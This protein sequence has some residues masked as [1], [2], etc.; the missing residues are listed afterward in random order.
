MVLSETARD[1]HLVEK[2]AVQHEY[3]QG[4]RAHYKGPSRAISKARFFSET[5]HSRSETGF[6]FELTTVHRSDLLYLASEIYA[7]IN[8]DLASV[9]YPC[10]LPCTYHL[11]INGS[12]MRSLKRQ[13]AEIK[14]LYVVEKID[15]LFINLGCYSAHGL[16]HLHV[17][18]C[19]SS[20]LSE[21]RFN[22][23][24]SKGT[25]AY[26][27]KMRN[28][29][30]R[31]AKIDITNSHRSRISS[32]K[33]QFSARDYWYMNDNPSRENILNYAMSSHHAY[34]HDIDGS[35]IKAE[36][37]FNFSPLAVQALQLRFFSIDRI[38]N[39]K[40]LK[41]GF[42]HTRRL[43][44]LFR[45]FAQIQCLLLGVNYS[46]I[47]TPAFQKTLQSKAFR[48]RMNDDLDVIERK[49]RRRHP[50][51][52][53]IDFPRVKDTLPVRP[54]L[55]ITLASFF[56]AQLIHELRV[57]LDESNRQILP[58]PEIPPFSARKLLCLRSRARS[59]RE[60]Y[61]HENHDYTVF[62]E[63]EYE[64]LFDRL[65]SVALQMAIGSESLQPLRILIFERYVYDLI[66]L[67][68]IKH[69]GPRPPPARKEIL[70]TDIKE[71]LDSLEAF[72]GL[73]PQTYYKSG[74]IEEGLPS[75][76]LRG[77][78]VYMLRSTVRTALKIKSPAKYN[79]YIVMDEYLSALSREI[80]FGLDPSQYSEYS[81]E[82]AEM[83]SRR[84]RIYPSHRLALKKA[85]GIVDVYDPAERDSL[86][87]PVSL[88]SLETYSVEQ[89]A[90]A[91][92][93]LNTVYPG[94]FP[95]DPIMKLADGNVKRR[96]GLP[97]EEAETDLD[98]SKETKVIFDTSYLSA[99]QLPRQSCP[100]FGEISYREFLEAR[101]LRISDSNAL[102][103]VSSR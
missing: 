30:I 55:F 76:Q 74:P 63:S 35:T 29:S 9:L 13:Y 51:T 21:V 42:Q 34:C 66:V 85:A 69:G 94:C 45:M 101:I 47:Y 41:H 100:W 91:I 43:H 19:S 37:K 89:H 56:P 22:R 46:Q 2:T 97:I 65:S 87:K 103:S 33:C 96:S 17:A 57:H 38:A 6:P 40:T 20:P 23:R 18:I 50:D 31:S 77:M 58:L 102:S 62:T 86:P 75:H 60:L 24:Q 16:L 99:F 5:R 36:E 70:E 67:E 64:R 73:G 88:D 92:E 79:Y 15:V 8:T 12:S 98:K 72:C 11:T 78:P 71:W 52:W 14:E 1:P 32:V 39:G 44:Y 80:E 54:N 61:F 27:R 3:Q 4:S 90:W 68:W 25:A 93:I 28:T 83:L 26:N 48:V 95:H 84:R 59:E 49:A 82:V 81:P 7:Q 53:N 10:S